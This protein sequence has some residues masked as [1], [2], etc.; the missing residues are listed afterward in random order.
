MHPAKTAHARGFTLIELMVV[1]FILGLMAAVAVPATGSGYEHRLDMVEIQLRDAFDRAANLARSTR[2]THG[3]VF[4]LTGDRFAVVDGSGDAVPDPLTKREYIV[5][6]TRPDQPK[7][8]DFANADFGANGVAA[9]FD[10]QGL[11]TAGGTVQI[12]CKD[13]TRTLS[14]D[15]ATGQVSVP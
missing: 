10:G 4:D 7:S 6:F 8:I 9:I 11:P 14:L 12:R 5:E 3:V 15:K 2:Q 13:A 1:L